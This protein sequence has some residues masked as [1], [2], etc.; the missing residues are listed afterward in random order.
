[1][2]P[3]GGGGVRGGVRVLTRR[4]MIGARLDARFKQGTQNRSG[5]L[6]V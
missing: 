6:P 4:P 2:G 3:P 5:A 1:V